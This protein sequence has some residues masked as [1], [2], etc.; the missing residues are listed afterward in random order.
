MIGKIGS[1]SASLRSA[2]FGLFSTISR[3]H[4]VV[5]AYAFGVITMSQTFIQKLQSLVGHTVNIRLQNVPESNCEL[6]GTLHAM[7]S[8]FLEIQSNTRTSWVPFTSI[9]YV[10]EQKK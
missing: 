6:D 9:S 3:V 5:E 10:S 2:G 1:S 8:D 7:N 4:N